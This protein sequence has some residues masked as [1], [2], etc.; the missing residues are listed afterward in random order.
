M[1]GKAPLQFEPG[2]YNTD[3]NKDDLQE[4]EEEDDDGEGEDNQTKDLDL[5]RDI[6]SDTNT[7]ENREQ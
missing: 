2:S 4:E 7:L 3:E 1:I 5:E 6:Q